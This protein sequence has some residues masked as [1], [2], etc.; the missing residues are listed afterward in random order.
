MIIIQ[1]K[2]KRYDTYEDTYLKTWLPMDK[3]VKEGTVISL[4]DVEGK[5]Q[6]VEQFGRD[7]LSNLKRGWNNN[8]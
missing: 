1:T 7:E 4:E 2:L 5:W 3:R 6:V 8:I